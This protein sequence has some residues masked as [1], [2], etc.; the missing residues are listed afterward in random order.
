MIG[1]GLLPPTTLVRPPKWR[2]RFDDGADA[3][4]CP[5]FST[6][7]PDVVEVARLYLHWDKGNLSAML[8]RKRINEAL[9]RGIET[10]H[11]ALMTLTNAKN[12][13]AATGAKS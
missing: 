12:R 7:L 8:P 2:H 1:C 3:T 13:D 10:L 6:S 4:V 5:G 11:V 9:R